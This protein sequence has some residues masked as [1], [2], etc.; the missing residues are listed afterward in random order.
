V[1]IQV[2]QVQ[3]VQEGQVDL[4]VMLGHKDL[5]DHKADKVFK[6]IKEIQVLQVLKDQQAHRDCKV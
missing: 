4:K 2:I 3:V 6:V 5:K 1:E